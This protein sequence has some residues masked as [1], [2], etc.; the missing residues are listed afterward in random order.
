MKIAC[1]CKCGF[2]HMVERAQC[3]SRA[4]DESDGTEH[5]CRHHSGH[6][7]NEHHAFVGTS[8]QLTWRRPKAKI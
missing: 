7:G 1:R 4:I 8:Q 3:S 2:V 5:Q 6:R